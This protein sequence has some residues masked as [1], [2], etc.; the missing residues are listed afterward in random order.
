MEHHL[1]FKTKMMKIGPADSAIRT[2]RRTVKR[3]PLA[4]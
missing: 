2:T 4:S 3:K 1:S